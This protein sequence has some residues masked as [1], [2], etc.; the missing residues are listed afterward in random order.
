MILL[1]IPIQVIK[2]YVKI[3]LI[4]QLL[5]LKVHMIRCCR[6]SMTED[7]IDVDELEKN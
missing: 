2:L 5:K 7:G 6:V 3:Q 4:I 1:H